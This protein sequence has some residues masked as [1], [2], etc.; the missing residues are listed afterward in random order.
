MGNEILTV[1]DFRLPLD[2]G[3]YI[4]GEIRAASGPLPKPVVILSHGFRGHKDWAFWPDVSRRL[5]ESGFYTVSFNYSRISA[6]SA[7]DQAERELAESAT[8]SRELLDLEHVVHSLK[9]RQLPWPELADTGK[10]AVLGHSRAGGSGILFAA[11]H[12]EIKA[13]IVWNGGSAPVRQP[14]D[15]GPELSLQEA[16]INEDLHQ[17]AADFNLEAALESLAAETLVIQGDQDRE[18]LLQQNRGFRSRA[19]QHRYLAVKGADHTFNTVHPYG[20]ATVELNEAL[21]E[22]IGFLREKLG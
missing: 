18:A 8:L 12:P 14:N 7:Q 4:E 1:A 22:S 13:L 6:R 20:G 15:G 9:L 11:A 3:L 21:T 5:A 19:P 2:N 16:V 10:L 17:H